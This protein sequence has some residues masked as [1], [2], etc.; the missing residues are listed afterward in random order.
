MILDDDNFAG[1]M[2]PI[3]DVLVAQRVLSDDTRNHVV[4]SIFQDVDRN[5]PRIEIEVG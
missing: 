1:A 5:N 3:F 2:K 4:R